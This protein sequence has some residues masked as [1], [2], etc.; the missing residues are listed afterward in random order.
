MAAPHSPRQPRRVDLSGST[1]IVTGA[2]R[3]IGQATA[4]A[5]VAAGANV[6]MTSRHQESADAAAAPFGARAAGFA[7]HAADEEAAQACVGFAIERFGSLDTLVNNAATNPAY[8]PVVEQDRARFMKTLEVNVWAPQM[9]ARQAW[10]MWMRDHGG[11][12]VNVASLGGLIVGPDIGTY[13]SSKAALIHMTRHLAR[14]LAPRV[15]VNAITP[16]VV[17]TR[18]A[19]ALWK[20]H[21]EA[22]ATRTALGRIAEPAD[23]ADV[24]V[25]LASDHARWITGETLVIDGG[26]ALCAHT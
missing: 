10:Q 14:E 15:R 16:G 25:F 2:S 22:D 20:E 4:A 8:G 13:N 1:V 21:E 3:G 5:L 26:E 9:W 6:V 19:E 7:A 11:V 24:V 12:I 17:K 18:M 23:I